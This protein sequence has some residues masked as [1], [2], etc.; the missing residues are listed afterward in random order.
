MRQPLFFHSLEVVCDMGVGTNVLDPQIQISYSDDGG[1]NFSNWRNFS[2]GKAGQFLKR[3][4]F[5]RL[6]MSKYGERVFKLRHSQNST[7]NVMNQVIAE[8]ESGV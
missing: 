1:Y 3:V 5:T 4:L 6:G 2:L 7:F 8:I